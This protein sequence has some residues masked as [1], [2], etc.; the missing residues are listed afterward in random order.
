MTVSAVEF[1]EAFVGR[2]ERFH[3]SSEKEVYIAFPDEIFQK[4]VAELSI[5]VE[6]NAH[7]SLK[8]K[9]E[10][11]DKYATSYSLLGWTI[12]IFSNVSDP[13]KT[14]SHTVAG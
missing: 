13:R 4:F 6:K 2:L 12:H 8:H 5:H 9:S 14:P 3:Q 10:K 11:E 7:T 1:L